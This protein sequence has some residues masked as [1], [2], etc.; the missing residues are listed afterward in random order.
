MAKRYSAIL[1]GKIL[2]SIYPVI[3]NNNNNNNNNSQI[4]KVYSLEMDPLVASIAMNLVSLAGLSDIVE[5]VVGS[6]AYTIRRLHANG[7]FLVGGIDLLFL[8]HVE[9]LY[10]AD[11]NLCEELGLLKPSGGLVVADN[12]LIPGAPKYREYVRGNERFKSWALKGLIIPGDLEVCFVLF[13]FPIQLNFYL[14]IYFIL[15]STSV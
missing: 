1:F 3:N 11:L 15:K 10:E 6:A 14:F 13:L 12:V 4:T 2:R 7:T 5:V 9:D 8:D